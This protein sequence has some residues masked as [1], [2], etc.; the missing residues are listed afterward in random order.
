[1]K[2]QSVANAL[3]NAGIL[4]AVAACCTLQAQQGKTT[5]AAQAAPYLVTPLPNHVFGLLVAHGD[6]L[7]MPGNERLTLSGTLTDAAGVHTATVT[8]EIPGKVLVQI[9]GAASKTLRFDGNLP[10]TDGAAL[11]GGDQDLL[12]S[13]QADVAENFFFSFGRSASV[14][15][16]GG[17]YRT[18]GGTSKNYTGPWCNGSQ[19]MPL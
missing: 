5:A 12:E 17:R 7:Q 6:R 13:F 4:F 9:S 19:R 11:A 18:D 16:L 8:A 2:T 14:R 3:R 10:S 15:F 1:M